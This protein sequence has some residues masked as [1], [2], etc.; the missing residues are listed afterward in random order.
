MTLP[1]FQRGYYVWPVTRRGYSMRFMH[2]RPTS[3]NPGFVGNV[4]KLL[5]GS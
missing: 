2:R 1:N 5:R 4:R 3:N